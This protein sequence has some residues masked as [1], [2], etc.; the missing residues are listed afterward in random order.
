MKVFL[1]G[2]SGF[3]G[4][5]LIP[6]LTRCHG[7]SVVALSR[8]AAS[9]EKIRKANAEI[10]TKGW[11]TDGVKPKVGT[12]EIVRGDVSTKD[13]VLEGERRNRLVGREVSRPR[14]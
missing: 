5:Q 9:D 7:D 6:Y 11:R 1:I 12:V 10:P 8:S 3:V 2:A 4:S 13:A 14:L